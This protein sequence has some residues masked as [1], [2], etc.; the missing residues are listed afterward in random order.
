MRTTLIMNS[1]YSTVITPSP[2]V[3]FLHS[4]F[5]NER[6]F[7]PCRSA[8]SVAVNGHQNVIPLVTPLMQGIRPLNITSFV[9]SFIVNAVQG[10]AWRWT[11]ANIINHFCDRL[12]AKF[13]TSTAVLVKSNVVRVFTSPFRTIE[14]RVFGRITI[15]MLCVSSTLSHNAIVSRNLL[16]DQLGSRDNRVARLKALGNGIVPQIA[17]EIFKAI[18][19]NTTPGMPGC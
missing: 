3:T 15:A 2:F 16:R 17:Y 10:M 4:S 5:R 11:Q 1:E 19:A 7:S 13:N 14:N 18:E 12:K 9:M 8:L 6:Y